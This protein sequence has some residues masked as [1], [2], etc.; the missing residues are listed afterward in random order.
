MARVPEIAQRLACSQSDAEPI[1]PSRWAAS[2]PLY[3]GQLV[4]QTTWRCT[5]RC[6]M[7]Y[8]SAGPNGSDIFGRAELTVSDLK[9]IF[10]DLDAIRMLEPHFHLVGGEALI[11]VET[12][13][14]LVDMARA[15]GF[16]HRTL[17]S[18]GFW[19]RNRTTASSLSAGLVKA[20]LTRLD[21]SWDRWRRPF[22]GANAISTCLEE[23]AACN[24]AVRLR[25]LLSTEDTVDDLLKDLR[26]N[27]VALADEIACDT[28][29]ATGR[30]ATSLDPRSI[31]GGRSLNAACF[32]DL[33]LTINP[34]GDVYPC[35][36]GLDQTR[37]LQFGNV[38]K[39]PLAEIV[40]RMDASP[41]LRKIVF[42][43]VASLLPLLPD[44]GRTIAASRSSICS[45]CWAI[46]SD[47][48]SIAAIKAHFPEERWAS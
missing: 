46:F 24:L 9:P 31:P 1:G 19:G 4:V 12:V 25:L 40:T 3:L 16:E 6:A 23:A 45:L 44:Q 27:A 28:V 39:T 18:N 48:N 41:L 17:T 22:I 15:A 11:N 30:A 37:S 26:P 13:Y 34:A 20:G 8:Q 43:G 33:R 21:L 36:S 38:R 29:A 14:A 7:C 5:A 35:C 47:P 42:D 2:A 32:R 10:T